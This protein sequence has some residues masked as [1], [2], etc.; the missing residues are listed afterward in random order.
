MQRTMQRRSGWGDGEN[1]RFCR[2]VG[3]PGVTDNQVNQSTDVSN[4]LGQGAVTPVSWD[5]MMNFFEQQIYCSLPS[6]P[7][8]PH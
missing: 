4:D 5:G 2:S 1:S 8:L 7:D 3:A 6:K